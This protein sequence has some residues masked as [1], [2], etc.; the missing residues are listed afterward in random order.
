[1]LQ[2]ISIEYHMCILGGRVMNYIHRIPYGYTRWMGVWVGISLARGWSTLY[3]WE[4]IGGAKV[5]VDTLRKERVAVEIKIHIMNI[6]QIRLEL[7]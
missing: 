2:T 7:E 6:C 4:S 1:M 5:R 3:G